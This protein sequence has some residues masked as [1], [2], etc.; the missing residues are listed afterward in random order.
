[1]TALG[2][3]TWLQIS[4]ADDVG[5]QWWQNPDCD[6]QGTWPTCTYLGPTGLFQ[7]WVFYN[8]GSPINW[9][10]AAGNAAFAEVSATL[11][12][13]TCY[14]GTRS[15]TAS[16]WGSSSQS[17]VT[18]HLEFIQLNST[19][20]VCK[21][22][23]TSD[24]TST[25]TNEAH[26][27]MVH[28]L[29][30]DVPIYPECD[31]TRFLIR[32]YVKYVSGNP[33]K[34]DGNY[35]MESTTNA[36]AINSAY[37]TAVPVPNVVGSTESAATEMILAAGYLVGNISRIVNTAPN[38]IVISQNAPG[39]TIE[40]PGSAV[41]LIIS[42]GGC[43]VPDITG[44]GLAAAREALAQA[45]CDGPQGSGPALVLGH[46]TRVVDF[47]CNSVGVIT[48]QSPHSGSTLPRGSAVD[49]WV[50][51]KPPPPHVCP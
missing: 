45:P 30:P 18:S 49:Y 15:C 8:D 50:G 21:T 35:G 7:S 44:M 9:W 20:G 23:Q 3:G 41:D 4:S 39:G 34:I 19:L 22:N 16:N 32:L 6:S 38:G 26:H 43:T 48:D 1:V 27:Y 51:V 14:H 40:A 11:E 29:L 10:A 47:Y 42:L 12:V 2:G 13:T 37:G 31:S 24:V 25:I 5:S 28:Y 36:Y 33:V 17:V 46:E